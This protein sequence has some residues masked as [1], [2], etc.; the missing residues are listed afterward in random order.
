MS[1]G[2]ILII[3]VVLLVI[4][5]FIRNRKLP[6]IPNVYTDVDDDDEEKVIPPLTC[7][8]VKCMIVGCGNLASHKVGEENIWDKTEEKEQYEKFENCHNLTTYLCEEHFD[9]VIT[10]EEKYNTIK[11][12]RFKK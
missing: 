2:V 5:L 9:F 8:G 7:K 1:P 6:I 12:N 10:R 4:L 3:C 11:D